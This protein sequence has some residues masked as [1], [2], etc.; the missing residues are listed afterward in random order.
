[1]GDRLQGKVAVVTG[2]ASGIGEATAREFVRQGAK[3]VIA[4]REAERTHT[5]AASLGDAARAIQC[6]VTDEAQ[7]AAAVDLAVS[8]WGRLDI[9]FNN[10]GI[11]GA[12]GAI[13]VTDSAGWDHTIAV[14][15]D[16]VMYGCK[17]AARVMIPQGSGSILSTTSIAGVIGGVGPHAYTAAKHGVIGLTKSVAAELAKYSIR[18]NAIAP[19]T[20]PT[21]LTALVVTG[22]PSAIDVMTEHAKRSSGM[23][24]APDA[25]DI[26]WAAVYLASDESRFVTGHTLAVDGGR[27]VTSG[28]SRYATST[29]GMLDA[30]A[31]K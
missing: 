2:A 3:V 15:L 14:L 4:G 11:V 16:G 26:A 18:V 27:T 8:T 12:T 7:V 24:F 31:P 10:A 6:E 21:P 23:G 1:M 17:H 28:S 29:S 9:M 20:I 5:V 13:D 30:E 19:G 22:D 25:T